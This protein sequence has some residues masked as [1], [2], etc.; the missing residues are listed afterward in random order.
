MMAAERRKQERFRP[1]DVTFVAMRPEFNRLGR[2]LDINRKGLCFQ[3]M[4]KPAPEAEDPSADIDIFTS[5]SRY[6]LSGV[7]CKIIYDERI[8]TGPGKLEDVEYRRCGLEF[9]NLSPVQTD[10]LDHYLE[11]HAGAAEG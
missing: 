2:L 9:F 7:L 11:K 4:I 1:E 3:Y 5:E 10:Q 8:D 6:Y